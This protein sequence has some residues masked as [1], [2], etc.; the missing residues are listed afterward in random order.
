MCDSNLVPRAADVAC[1][2]SKTLARRGWCQDPRNSMAPARSVLRPSRIES[3]LVD[4]GQIEVR[5]SGGE[6]CSTKASPR[7]LILAPGPEGQFVL[8]SYSASERV[9]RAGSLRRR[10]KMRRMACRGFWDLPHALTYRDASTSPHRVQLGMYF[11]A[12]RYS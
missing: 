2:M 8:S 12:Q 11:D 6:I 5:V 10:A 9:A 1:Q 4:T 7:A 3:E